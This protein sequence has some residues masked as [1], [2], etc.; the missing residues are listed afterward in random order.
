MRRAI[1]LI[2]AAAIAGVDQIAGDMGMSR[3]NF[4]RPFFRSGCGVSPKRY[5]QY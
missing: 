2:D 3:P 4:Q 1:D 5:Q